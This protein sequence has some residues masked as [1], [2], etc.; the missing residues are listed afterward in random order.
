VK[1]VGSITVPGAPAEVFPQNRLQPG[2]G[3]PSQLGGASGGMGGSVTDGTTL[4]VPLFV[5]PPPTDLAPPPNGSP[6]GGLSGRSTLINVNLPADGYELQDLN[7]DFSAVPNITKLWLEPNVPSDDDRY[8]RWH[9][10]FKIK[11][12]VDIHTVRV[13]DDVNDPNYAGRMT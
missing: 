10:T 6:T 3:A 1:V 9:P 2:A 8:V 5:S 4:D 11:S 12:L 7:R 13:V